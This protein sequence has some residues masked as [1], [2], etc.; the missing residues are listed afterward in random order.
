MLF[1]P[2]SGSNR[3]KPSRLAS[4]KPFLKQRLHRKQWL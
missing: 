1:N 3:R 2:V 4:K